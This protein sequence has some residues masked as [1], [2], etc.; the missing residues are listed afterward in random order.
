MMNIPK[1]LIID[2][3]R[4]KG[5]FGFSVDTSENGEKLDIVFAGKEIIPVPINE[6]AHKIYK[7]L[8]KHCDVIF[9]TTQ[10][11]DDFPFYPVPR[12]SIF[13]VDT[14]DNCFGTIS[15]FG[16]IVDDD[17]PVGYV[18]CKGMNGKIA[19]SLKEFLELVTFYPYWWDII[20]CEQMGVSYDIGAMEIGKKE[21]NSQYF[22]R[23]REIQETL[24]LSN[25]SKSIEL[26]ISNIKGT[27]EFMVYASKDEARKT[28]TFLDT[29]QATENLSN[30]I[31]EIRLK[32]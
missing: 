26:L 29:L 7:L 22:A 15:G 10:V 12:F 1:R 13:A 8:E 16:N 28:N 30:L 25:N 19:N 18:S 23:Q 27:H 3:E 2:I 4:N 21:N 17:Y 5:A 14:E 24:K 6:R 20:R 31:E 32:K 9:C 11:L